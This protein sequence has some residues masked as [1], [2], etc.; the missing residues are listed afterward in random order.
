MDDR[1][2]DNRK[3]CMPNVDMVRDET[4]RVAFI[5]TSAQL[6][7]STADRFINSTPIVSIALKS[8]L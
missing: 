3:S 1:G 8:T 5:V 6:S 4:C 7:P 2:H